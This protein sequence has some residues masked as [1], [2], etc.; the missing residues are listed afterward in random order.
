MSQFIRPI[1]IDQT[2]NQFMYKLAED[3]R[4]QRQ[5]ERKLKMDDEARKVELLNSID[6][7]VL[8]KNF[9]RDVVNAS[10]N[11]LQRNVASYLRQNPNGTSQDLQMYLQKQIG[12][13]AQWSNAAQTIRKNIEGTVAAMKDNKGVDIAGLSAAAITRAL[14][15]PDGSLKTADQLDP[16]I[17]YAA[18]AYA[19]DPTKFIDIAAS[20]KMWEDSKKNTEKVIRIKSMPVM[21]DG[22]RV[23]DSFKFEVKPWQDVIEGGVVT[24]IKGDDGYLRNDIYDAMVPNG[25]AVDVYWT[26]MAKNKIAEHN[27]RVASGDKIALKIGAKDISDP[28]NLELV[29]R[30]LITN[31]LDKLSGS[32]IEDVDKGLRVYNN[33]SGGGS[34]SS[35]SSPASIDAYSKA[36][37]AEEKAKKFFA[38]DKKT[39][40]GKTINSFPSRIANVFV[41][42]ANGVSGDVEENV[43]ESGEVKKSDKRFKQD[44]L[45]VNLMPNG[46]FQIKAWRTGE[47]LPE[48]T[49]EE[50]N[51]AYNKGLTK[52]QAGAANLAKPKITNQQTITKDAFRKMS[53]PERQKFITAGGKVQ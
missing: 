21:K 17:D 5:L 50:L 31:D 43:D 16:N 48:V 44:D 10:I 53:I 23:Q 14:R 20:G 51:M 46:N 12:G 37:E 41:N 3:M 1:E 26:R 36:I 15:N 29:K 22:K 30:A 13:V 42:S 11:D 27:A 52:A 6:P 7:A 32:R 47:I 39:F 34:G 33:T 38:A 45:V 24:T 4:Q 25:S 9:D 28:T 8:N 19:E 35:G 2:P 49:P 18:Q 40:L